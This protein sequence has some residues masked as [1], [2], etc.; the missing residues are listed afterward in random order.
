MGVTKRIVCLANSR[1]WQGRCIAGREI[2]GPTA[3]LWVRAVSDRSH[4]EVSDL[5]C[6]YEGGLGNPRLLD[7]LDI[8]MI[9]AR[10]KSYQQE[11][12]LLDPTKFWVKT[13]EFARED[14]GHLIE[15][16]GPLWIDGFHRYNDRVPLVEAASLDSSLRFIGVDDLEIV[17]VERPKRRV[18]ARFSLRGTKY[19]LWVTDPVV[20]KEYLARGEGQYWVGCSYLTISLSEAYEGFCYK[21]VA[22]VIE[23]S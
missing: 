17:I 21:L 13:G 1:K 19:L 3:G 20:E 6:L 7:T 9:E 11:N 8:P 10:P 23:G 5:E 16:L 12:W 22:A 15:P 18:R 2:T 14:A 4:E